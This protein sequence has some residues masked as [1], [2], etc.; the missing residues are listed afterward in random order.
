M[1]LEID[2][3]FLEHPKTLGF[4]RALADPNAAAYLLRL[5]T[6]ATKSAPDGDL[7]S[8]EPEDLELV[9]RWLGEPGACYRALVRY[10]F[11][12]ESP[13]ARSIHNWGSRTGGAIAR[14]EMRAEEKRLAWAEQK[15]RQRARFKDPKAENEPHGSGAS[16]H[17]RPAR[18]RLDIGRTATR[19][20]PPKTSRDE[21]SQDESEQHRAPPAPRAVNQASSEALSVTDGPEAANPLARP[22]A[23]LA[24]SPS[25]VICLV[26][27]KKTP[28]QLLACFGRVRV[29]ALRRLG[30]NPSPWTTL[31]PKAIAKAQVLLERLDD[32]AHERLEDTMRL[33]FQQLAEPHASVD[34]RLFS[35]EFGF[36][37]WVVRLEDLLEQCENPLAAK[38]PQRIHPRDR[39]R[40]QAIEEFAA[41]VP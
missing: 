19:R 7:S 40:M 14:M 6:W 17:D 11:V 32:R 2:D 10:R 16:P 38:P 39:E 33:F 35:K 34:A 29:E 37:G 25:S 28:E 12:D 8:L 26:P 1:Y 36:A 41:R 30:R 13:P 27:S 24:T 18:V 5:W 31:G 15:R 20:P 3:G 21:T 23:A 22:S 4:C 9:I